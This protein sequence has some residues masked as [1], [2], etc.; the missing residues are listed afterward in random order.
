MI[1]CQGDGGAIVDPDV[2]GD[3]HQADAPDQVVDVRAA[4][5]DVP[6]HHLTWARIRWALVRMNPK[7]TRKATKNRNSG[8]AA[9][10]DDRPVV[11][12]RRCWRRDEHA[13]SV[14]T[15]AG[16]GAREQ[17]D[18][19]DVAALLD[20]AVRV[21]GAVEGERLGDHGLQVALRRAP[22]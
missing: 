6:G 5:L 15:A 16:R 22:P 2:A 17:H 7:V 8:L 1:S 3:H 9:G 18:L 20:Q 14:T 11:E 12:A 13:L 4:H 10:V 19:A 21:G